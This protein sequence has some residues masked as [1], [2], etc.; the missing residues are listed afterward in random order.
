M[1]AW[2]AFPHASLR[3]LTTFA[4][5]SE[6]ALVELLATGPGIL[7]AVNALK[8]ADAD[9]TIIAMTATHL[10][11]PDGVGAVLG[12]AP[13]GHPRK[14]L[15]GADLWLRIVARYVGERS[16]HLVGGTEE[17]IEIVAEKLSVRYPGMQLRYRNGYLA[18][19]DRER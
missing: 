13:A 1:A 2:S 17:V 14:R 19:G 12:V 16:F 4:P 10:G 9:P 11:Y 3:G 18:A 15:P 7:L 6:A 8:V 5:P